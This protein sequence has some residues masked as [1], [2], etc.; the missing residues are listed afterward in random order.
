[1]DKIIY[2]ILYQ[3]MGFEPIKPQCLIAIQE[4]EQ[5]IAVLMC[6]HE[7][8]K[9]FVITNKKAPVGANFCKWGG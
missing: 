4:F 8:Y 9:T 6:R 3:V 1:M 7:P 2:Y 5:W